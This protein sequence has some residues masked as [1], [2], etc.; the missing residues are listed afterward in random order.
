M[1]DL[2]TTR[3][4]LHAVAELLVAGPQYEM[5]GTIKLR[6]SPGGFGTVAEPD[7]R[8]AGTD[9]LVGPASVPLDG[10]TVAEVGARAGVHPRPLSDVFSGGCGLTAEHLLAVDAGWAAHLA[11]AFRVGDEALARFAPD[12]P[13][14]L[15]PEHFDLGISLHEVNYGLSPGDS[16]LAI[17]YAYV[18]PWSPGDFRGAFWDAPFGATRPL[19][20]LGSVDGVVAFF[21]EGRHLTAQR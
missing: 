20:E 13:R 2:E 5:S 4:A 14:V 18:G 15:W 16:Y 9:L 19:D 3:R 12:Q 6:V 8:V 11:E 17:P 10:Y 7:A 1:A 21:D